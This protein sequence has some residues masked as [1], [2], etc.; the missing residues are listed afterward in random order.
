MAG[1]KAQLVIGV[2]LGGDSS[3]KGEEGSSLRSHVLGGREGRQRKV[4]TGERFRSCGDVSPLPAA[5]QLTDGPGVAAKLDPKSFAQ[6]LCTGMCHLT[7]YL[8]DTVEEGAK[9]W[10][11]PAGAKATPLAYFGC[12][13]LVPKEDRQPHEVIDCIPTVS[14]RRG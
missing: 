3:P 5:L 14:I 9:A 13:A 7:T 8:Q 4:V 11:A 2:C 1:P 10:V 6:G 12:V